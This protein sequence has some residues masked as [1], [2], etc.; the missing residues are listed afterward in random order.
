MDNVFFTEL[1]K[2]I[3]NLTLSEEDSLL[4]I[5]NNKLYTAGGLILEF[6][7]GYGKTINIISNAFSPSI[8][9]GFDSFLGYPEDWKEG[10][11]KG[12]NACD[13]PNT[14][15]N[16]K[17]HL[18]TFDKSVPTFK[19]NFAK[20]LKI[21]LMHLDCGLYSSTKIVLDNLKDN[22]K[23]DAIIIISD[24][25]EYQGY[26]THSL[27]AFSEFL[28]EMN[29]KYEIV[30]YN[31]K[32][33]SYPQ[34]IVFKIIEN[35]QII[36]PKLTKQLSKIIERNEE[37]ITSTALSYLLIVYSKKE[38]FENLINYIYEQDDLFK[39]IYIYREKDGKD[40][41]FNML[42][43]I[44]EDS[45]YLIIDDINQLLDK[46]KN[47][48]MPLIICYDIILYFYGNN[49]FSDWINFIYNNSSS[50][51]IH[52]PN[53]VNSGFMDYIHQRLFNYNDKLSFELEFNNSK[54][55]KQQNYRQIHATFL[56]KL[57]QNKLDEYI[58]IEHL[59]IQSNDLFEPK[60]WA[61]FP[62]LL[63]ENKNRK[64]L[65]DLINNERK[66]VYGKSLCVNYICNEQKIN[67]Y[68][69]D[70]SIMKRYNIK[71]DLTSEYI[72][73]YLFSN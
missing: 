32:T 22:I 27:K 14:E 24:C 48:N 55:F 60:I 44:G 8:I 61:L 63:T 12:T 9:H 41:Y 1:R 39:K 59:I 38:Y 67:K 16:V 5:L 17:L 72:R 40:D 31:K 28:S 45:K 65:E 54:I 11:T 62:K 10:I 37:Q 73:K 26:E 58:N 69:S 33:A 30:S 23:K 29:L 46:L 47:Q 53:I 7:V 49:F 64:C 4:Y 18:K 42:K 34:R 51:I 25:M 71:C 21:T 13:I 20:N 19:K 52:T 35:V 56:N 70:E 66:Y 68:D 6:G 2:N 57:D 3:D 50:F 43:L 15:P 36:P